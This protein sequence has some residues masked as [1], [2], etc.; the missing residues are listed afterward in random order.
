MNEE[1]NVGYVPE[2]V[3]PPADGLFTQIVNAISGAFS[4]LLDNLG[5]LVAVLIV[6]F[7]A[8]APLLA[9]IAAF[10]AIPYLGA[11]AIAIGELGIWAYGFLLFGSAML[12]LPEETTQFVE[13]VVTVV[14]ETT[15]TVISAV[16]GGVS[17][18]LGLPKL[19]VWGGAL[20]LLSSFLKGDKQ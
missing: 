3:N 16:V 11:M 7:I 10:T 2:P 13:D 19:V 18:G 15:A 17:A 12:L 1:D 8:L 5:G 6:A 9:G 14:A 20:W 4:W